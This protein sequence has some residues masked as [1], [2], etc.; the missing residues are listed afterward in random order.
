MKMTERDLKDGTEF[1]FDN[2]RWCEQNDSDH[3]SD[4]FITC[5]NGHFSKGLFLI[6]FNGKCIHSSKT[7]KSAQKRLDKLMSDWNCEFKN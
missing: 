7:F 4:G 2:E 3:I 6:F 5:G 1:H